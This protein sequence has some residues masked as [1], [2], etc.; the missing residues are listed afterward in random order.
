MRGADET[1]RPLAAG[2]SARTV[3]VWATVAQAAVAFVNFGLPSVGPALR[4]VYGLSLPAYGA[5]VTS[6]LLGA[7]ASLIAWGFL[8]D[9]FGSRLS[10]LIGTS[11]A[12]A[13]VVA[14]AAT[15]SPA[16]LIAALFCSG[17]GTSV[18]PIAGAGALF[19]A[20]GAE[21]RA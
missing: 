4:D 21:R 10:V 20:Y 16:V 5:A 12:V 8:V 1:H 7:A 11:I 6:T 13:S 3:L 2:P 18:I 9:R 14:A 17:L 15:T 19:K